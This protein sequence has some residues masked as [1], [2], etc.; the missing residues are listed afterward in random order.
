M[1]R[2]NE[3]DDPLHSGRGEEGGGLLNER[4]RVLGA[5]RTR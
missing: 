1:G 3:A 2:E 4:I 5:E